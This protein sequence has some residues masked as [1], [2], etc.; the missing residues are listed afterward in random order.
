MKDNLLVVSRR[1][2]KGNKP[3]VSVFTLARLVRIVGK[4][5]KV[6]HFMYICQQL[7]RTLTKET[8]CSEKEMF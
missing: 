5:I 6:V 4:P 7:Q 2:F 8:K 3:H 1:S